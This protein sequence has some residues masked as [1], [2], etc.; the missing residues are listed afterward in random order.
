MLTGRVDLVVLNEG[1]DELRHVDLWLFPER[2]SQRPPHLSEVEEAWMFPGPFS[3]GGMVIEG[4]LTSDGQACPVTRVSPTLARVALPDPQPPGRDMTLRVRFRTRV[5][6]RFGPF[7][8]ASGQLT[9]DGGFFPRPPPQGEGGFLAASPPS[10]IA[11]ELSLSVKRSGLIGVLNGRVHRLGPRPVT[12]GV[13]T[14]DRLSLAVMPAPFVSRLAEAGTDLVLLHRR[15]RPPSP[16][17]DGLASLGAIDYAGQ[18]L[19]TSAL[20]LRFLK[21]SLGIELPMRLSLVEAPIRRDLAIEAPGMV[22]VSDRAFDVPGTERLRRLHRSALLRQVAAH[23]IRPLIGPREPIAWRD[24]VVDLAAINLVQRWEDAR[25]GAEGRLSKALA[26]GDFMA[27][28]DEVLYAPQLPFQS[29]YFR[30][31]DDTDRFRDRWSMFSHEAPNGQRLAVKLEDLGGKENLRRLVDKLIGGRSF[32]QAYAAVYPKAPPG[33]LAQWDGPY[34]RVNYDLRG[35][36]PGRDEAGA[37][38]DVTL[39]RTGPKGF[40]E[41]VTVAAWDEMGRRTQETW[42][43]VG[44][45]GRLRLRLQGALGRVQIDPQGRLIESARE[46]LADPR[47]DNGTA[48]TWKFLLQGGYLGFESASSSLSGGL[49]STIKRTNSADDSWVLEAYESGLGAGMG[50]TYRHHFG[51][52][53]RPNLRRY[54]VGIALNSVWMRSNEQWDDGIG[55]SLS[56]TLGQSSYLSRMNPQSGGRWSLTASLRADSRPESTDLAVA[57]VADASRLFPLASGQVLGLRVNAAAVFG[58]VSPRSSWRLGGA[59]RL[60]ALSP[61]SAVGALRLLSTLEWRH[62][63]TRDINLN[64]AQ[65]AWVTSVYGVAFVDAVLLADAPG[66]LFTHRSLFAGAGYGLRLIY[67]AMGLYPVVVG[68]D[69]AFAFMGAPEVTRKSP[70]LSV[71]MTVGQTF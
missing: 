47:S 11:Y 30:P 13:G 60:R 15:E 38:V 57:M 20:F 8:R 32:H 34:P 58:E 53:I 71:L 5:P 59:R 42:L 39:G 62:R 10:P 27:Q 48:R 14:A 56:L 17:E 49:V 19:A 40:V 45:I 43:G 24:R 54:H 28:V 44:A 1:T 51:R 29:A 66:D 36:R 67:Y 21:A 25:Y 64:L 61:L 23:L 50:V 26:A 41:P 7:G 55:T 6:Q 65:V 9:L 33:F 69:G 2:L 3:P 31:P 35:V 22:L 18:T 4:V 70:P 16:E 63:W 12:L 68:L 52:Y 37:F 46:G